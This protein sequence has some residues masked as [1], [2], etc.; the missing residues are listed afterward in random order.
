V[1]HPLADFNGD[2]TLDLALGLWDGV[3]ILYLKDDADDPFGSSDPTHMGSAN[4]TYNSQNVNVVDP[5]LALWYVGVRVFEFE[6]E[7]LN[8]LLV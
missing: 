4:F 2:G 6:F 1:P 3:Q 7:I 8:M 5:L